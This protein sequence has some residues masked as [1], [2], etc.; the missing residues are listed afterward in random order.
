MANI[1]VVVTFVM[2]IASPSFHVFSYTVVYHSMYT[3]RKVEK[4]NRNGMRESQLRV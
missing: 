3:L 1:G 2:P 4:S